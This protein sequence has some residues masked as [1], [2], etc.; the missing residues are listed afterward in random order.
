M[1]KTALLIGGLGLGAGLIYML[2]P[3]RG[4]RRRVMARSQLERYRRHTDDLWDHTTRSLGRQARE[5]FARAP[6]ARRYRRPGPGELLLARA[7]QLGILKSMLMLGCTGLGAGMMYVLDP[8]L[9]RRRRALVRD[10]AQAYWR[11]TGKFISQTARDARQ[12][13]YGLLAETQTQLRGAAVPEDTVLVARVRAQIGH[14]VSRA[15]SV[16][17]TAHQ[18]RV[19][20]SGSIA[21]H[22]VEKLLSAVAAVAGVTAVIN[23]LE[24]NQSTTSVADGR[25]N[26]TTRAGDSWGE[27]L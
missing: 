27:R 16:D 1:N 7:E 6:L 19:T 18:G 11:R 15:G 14:V 4:E 3:E 20:L 13:A 8:R 5:L 21:A 10:K 2:D 9:G 24:V 22:E 17:V 23:R 25:H 26:H 12:R